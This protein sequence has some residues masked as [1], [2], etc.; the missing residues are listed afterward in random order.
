[1]HAGLTV[2]R[3][4]NS[5]REDEAI[6]T[7]KGWDLA[8]WVDLEELSIDTVD[9]IGID[10]LEIDVVGDS[11]GLDGDAAWVALVGVELSERHFEDLMV[12]E[13]GWKEE[14]S[15]GF[16]EAAVKVSICGAR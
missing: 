1:M 7:D 12:V 13:D 10:N 9:D 5:L 2:D 14:G 3:N 11:D 15:T 4:G 6:S 8:E 16:Y